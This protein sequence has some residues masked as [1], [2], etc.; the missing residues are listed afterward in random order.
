MAHMTCYMTTFYI[1]TVVRNRSTATSVQDMLIHQKEI[2]IGNRQINSS[3]FVLKNSNVGS[4]K[5]N[6]LYRQRKYKMKMVLQLYE[7]KK[8]SPVVTITVESSIAPM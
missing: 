4:Y 6:I 2:K 7:I 1:P 5:S 8:D 3:L